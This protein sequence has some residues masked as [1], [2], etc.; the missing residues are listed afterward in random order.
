MKSHIDSYKDGMTYEIFMHRA[1][2]SSDTSKPGMHCSIIQNL[3]RVEQGD[4][5]FEKWHGSFDKQFK[6]VKDYMHKAMDK[7][8]KM[9]NIPPENLNKLEMLNSKIDRANSTDDLFSII[10]ETIELTHSVKIY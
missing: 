6:K 9:K 1:F 8:F 10:D 5:S 3:V 2:R 7:Y 4:T